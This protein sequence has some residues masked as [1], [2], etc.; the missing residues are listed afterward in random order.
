MANQ[1]ASL[2]MEQK[3]KKTPAGEIPVDW[4]AWT[5]GEMCLRTPEYGANVSAIEFKPEWPRYVRVTDIDDAGVLSS[6]DRKSI[7]VE[8]AK[9]YLLGVGDIIFARSGATVG[10]T[11]L[12]RKSD[13]PCAFA[14][15]TIRFS[16]DPQRLL[17]EFLFQFTHSQLYYQWVKGMLRA[18]AQ[19]NINGSEYSGLLLP[20]PPLREQKKIAEILSAVDAAIDKTNA[21]IEKAE[22]LKLGLMRQLCLEGMA[23]HKKFKMTEL[24]R[25]P[26]SWDLQPCEKLCELITVGIVVQPARLYTDSGVPCFR[27]LNILEDSISDDRM[28]FI[29]PEANEAHS[30][31]RLRE[32]DVVAVRTGYPGTACVVPKKIRGGPTVSI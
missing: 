9:Q 16:P 7:K 28:V 3:L 31:S 26:E 15:Y 32:G 24:G 14:G 11:Y 8:D 19:P 18:G 22:I 13:G 6:T 25:I 17:P 12:Y 5:L 10:K 20:I 2:K 23:K 1:V 29:S 21:V 4:E 30:K 27:S